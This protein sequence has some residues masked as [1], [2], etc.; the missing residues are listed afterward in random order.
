MICEGPKGVLQ[1]NKRNKL[2]SSILLVPG[3]SYIQCRKF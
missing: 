3:G 1:N 2:F